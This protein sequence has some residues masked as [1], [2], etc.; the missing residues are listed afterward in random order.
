MDEVSA[1]QHRLS[2]ST[3]TNSPPWPPPPQIRKIPLITRSIIG[4]VLLV[5]LPILL[6]FV[7]AYKILFVPSLITTNFELWRLVTPF[8]YGGDGIALLFDVFLIFRN[9]SELEEGAFMGRTADYGELLT[10]ATT[11]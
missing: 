7:S 5:T 8:L 4:G 9:S 3:R 11:V 10:P 1:E 2:V 6:K